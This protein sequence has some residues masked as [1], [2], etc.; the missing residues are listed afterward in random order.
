VEILGHIERP[1]STAHCEH[2]FATVAS[3]DEQLDAI[4]R[5]TTRT[6]WQDVAHLRRRARDFDGDDTEPLS[7]GF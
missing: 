5:R 1:H 7:C 2:H 3:K 4:T 6:P